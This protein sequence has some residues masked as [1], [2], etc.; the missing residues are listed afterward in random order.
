MRQTIDYLNSLDLNKEDYI[1]VGCS[2]GP[3]S[4]C[5][6]HT[7][8]KEKYRIVCAHVNHNIRKES[9]EEY[10]FLEDYCRERKIIFEGLELGEHT[11]ENEAYYR[12]KRYDFYRKIA[13]KYATR[14]IMTAHHGDD[15]VETV[16]MRISRGSNLR[17][18]AGFKKSYEENGY[19]IIKPLI[20][21]NKEEILEYDNEHNIPY[22]WDKTN[23]E[24]NY[25]R[26]RYR[27]KVLSF[28]KTED[29]HIHQKYLKFSE[30]IDR[31]VDFIDRLVE[32]AIERNYKDGKLDLSNFFEDDIYIQEKEL[33]MILR[34]LY[35]DDVALL[36]K[37]H[38]E[39]IL[40]NL[41]KKVNFKISLPKG[42]TVKRQYNMLIFNED[43][44]R[45]SKQYKIELKSDNKLPNGDIIKMI[46]ATEDCSN[47]TTRLSSLELATPLFIRTRKKSDTMEIKNLK[48]SKKLKKIFIDEKI[49]VDERDNHPIVVDSKDRIVWLP[50]I[51]KSKLDINKE[52]KYDIILKYIKG[53]EKNY[54]K[55]QPK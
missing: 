35:S 29:E 24:D 41:N 36:K 12:K 48:G 6:I 23:D 25:T 2:G 5:L 51:R 37:V 22:V 18:Y 44:S 28:L 32:Q 1:V 49:S 19:F 20:F 9:K 52:G 13:D 7:L 34:E 4:M 40:K 11:D 38:V 46:D 27:H 21:Y 45:Y 14:I 8:Y 55:K 43:K 33:E 31:T 16:L 30:T 50:G 39:S 54:E 42:V 10:R 15:L 26:N 3:D 47:F 53:K 17:G